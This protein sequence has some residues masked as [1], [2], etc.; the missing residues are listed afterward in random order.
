MGMEGSY[1]C[2]SH[3]RPD[4]RSLQ[5]DVRRYAWKRGSTRPNRSTCR[6]DLSVRAGFPGVKNSRTTDSVLSIVAS[7]IASGRRRPNVD[8]I[9]DGGTS[10]LDSSSDALYVSR[11]RDARK[12]QPTLTMWSG[13]RTVERSTTKVT[14]RRCA[15]TV[16][17]RSAEQAAGCRKGMGV[18]ISVVDA[19]VDR[20]FSKF[21]ISAKF[22]FFMKASLGSLMQF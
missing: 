13:S 17:T 6:Y 4:L 9:G 15:R 7:V 3:G 18:E 11:A 1:P 19:R 10:G 22:Q 5:C 21:F 20:P 8:T 16:M 14:C 2:V 12:H